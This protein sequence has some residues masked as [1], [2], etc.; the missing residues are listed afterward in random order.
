MPAPAV[1]TCNITVTPSSPKVGEAFT[2]KITTDPDSFV[3][4]ITATVVDSKGKST[5]ATKPVTILNPHTFDASDD[6]GELAADA[7]DPS[8]FHGVAS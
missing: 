7:L 2:V 4:T 3:D 8:L 1:P 6:A 5:T